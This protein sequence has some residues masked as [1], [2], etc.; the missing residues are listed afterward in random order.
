MQV[1]NE[2]S[3]SPLQEIWNTSQVSEDKFHFL[4]RHATLLEALLLPSR[5]SLLGQ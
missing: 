5:K 4:S 3:H 2:D 1:L